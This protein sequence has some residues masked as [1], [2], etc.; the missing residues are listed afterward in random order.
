MSE[1]PPVKAPPGLARLSLGLAVGTLAWAVPFSAA[2]TVL[3]PS[4]I[5]RVAPADKVGL[6]ATV[7]ITGSLAA[8]VA[9]VLFGVASDATRSRFGAR[10]PWI[11]AGGLM[12]AACLM[13]LASVSS[14]PAV[15]VWWCCFQASMNALIAPLAAVLPD[16]VAVARR[17][18]VSAVIGTALVIGQAI[19]VITGAAFLSD[20][21]TGFLILAGASV[22]LTAAFVALAPDRPNRSGA[23]ATLTARHVL[24]RFR[25]PYGNGVGDFYWALFG[26]LLLIL[27]YFL[28]M[29]YMLYILTDHMHQSSEQAQKLI[30]LTALLTLAGSLVGASIAGPLSDTLGRRKAPVFV[31]SAFIGAAAIVP[32]L[33]ARP[34]AMLVFAAVA[35]L[36]LGTYTSVDSALV[37]EVLP[38][39]ASRGRDLGI[40]NMANTGGQIAAPAITSLVVA[41]LGGFQVVFLASAA[42]CVLAALAILPIRSVR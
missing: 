21:A 31:S 34:A 15:F 36:G 16:R 26:R 13:M 30:T 8:L 6:L 17:G 9:N 14:L 27:G 3:L 38:D 7:T 35:G 4:L 11:V 40:L 41:D 12:S 32:F 37:S 28:I 5:A 19:G 33:Q 29:G 10:N 1:T 2:T 25:L 42:F 22:L 24:S 23:T 39:E 20:P 18:A